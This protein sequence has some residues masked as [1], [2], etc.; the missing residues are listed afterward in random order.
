MAATTE[1]LVTIRTT[2]LFHQTANRIQRF[3]L[4]ITGRTI[5]KPFPKSARVHFS[6]LFHIPG[7]S[8]QLTNT[9]FHFTTVTWKR[10]FCA[11]TGPLQEQTFDTTLIKAQTFFCQ[12]VNSYLP[13]FC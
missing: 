12:R 11:G 1:W 2:K 9:N 4:S 8:T 3:L 6:W 7:T 13:I 5:L 10:E